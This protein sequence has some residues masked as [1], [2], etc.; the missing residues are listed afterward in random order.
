MLENLEIAGKQ[1][2]HA[3]LIPEVGYP[4]HEGRQC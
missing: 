3:F 2:H 4:D 1:L